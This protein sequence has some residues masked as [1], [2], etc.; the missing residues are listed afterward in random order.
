MALNRTDLIFGISE[1]YNENTKII[2]YNWQKWSEENFTS[3]LL[4]DDENPIIINDNKTFIST[5][6][7]YFIFTK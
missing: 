7:E 5:L 2:E 1:S 4:K 6:E 3:F